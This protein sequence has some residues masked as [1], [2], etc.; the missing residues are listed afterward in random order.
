MC[1]LFEADAL[2]LPLPDGVLDLIAIAFGFRNLVD[3]HAGFAEMYRVLKPSGMAAILE[4]S[5]PGGALFGT[6]YGFYSR[7]ILPIIGGALSGSR[8]A[9]AYLP[10]SIGKFPSA[11]ELAD[12]MRKAGFQAVE[13]IRFTGG[14][15][16]LHLG[17]K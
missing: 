5:Q 14:T 10:E 15:V 16:A 17:T 12:E 8:D 3:Y 2:A 4:F 1:P 9:Y 6:M 7:K 13:F 11:G